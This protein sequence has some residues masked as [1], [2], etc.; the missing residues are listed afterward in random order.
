MYIRSNEYF[1]YDG[2]QSY[3]YGLRFAWM[4]ESPEKELVSEKSYS[5]IRNAANNMFAVSSAK[6]E[7]P[8]EFQA[9]IVSDR[10]LTDQEVR[11][12]YSMF[13][14]KNQYKELKIPTES[15]ENI[16]F[17]CVITNIEKEEGGYG[18]RYGVV[19]FS[20]TVICDAPWGWT[21]EKKVTYSVH[22]GADGKIEYSSDSEYTTREG[23]PSIAN[24]YINNLTDSQDYIYPEVELIIPAAADIYAPNGA[25][26]KSK[27]ISRIG[28]KYSCYGCNLYDTC[29][30]GKNL[31]DIENLTPEEVAEITIR[32][33]NIPYKG[34]LLNLTDD[35]GRGTCFICTT[36]AQ[37]IKMNPKLGAINGQNGS[38][39][40]NGDFISET[41]GYI[42]KVIQ[43]NKKFIRLVPGQN[44]IQL[45]NVDT[46]T[47]KFREARIL[48]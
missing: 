17:N 35:M 32:D 13:F 40:A 16:H 28:N 14:D 11:R 18:D 15:G 26:D 46:I 43:T 6:Y 39:N 23:H 37:K 1:T 31:K 9:E 2:H 45:E 42:P 3:L 22:D 19:G 24:I 21:D 44:Q 48:V 10:V 8:L 4:E 41:D 30:D 7:D 25:S 5:H 47:F 36:K 27:Y 20:V 34:M 29:L 38:I 33:N 12:V